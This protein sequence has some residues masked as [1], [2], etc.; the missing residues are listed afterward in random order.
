MRPAVSTGRLQWIVD[1][2]RRSATR[3]LVQRICTALDAT[4]RRLP[5]QCPIELFA[6]FALGRLASEL[7]F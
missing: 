5:T 2:R 1:Q 7:C 6:L 3:Q 4:R